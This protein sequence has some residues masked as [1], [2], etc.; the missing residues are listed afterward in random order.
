[1]PD[2]DIEYLRFFEKA[3]QLAVAF[4]AVGKNP[5]LFCRFRVGWRCRDRFPWLQ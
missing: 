3:Q 1:M 2:L 4:A 5:N